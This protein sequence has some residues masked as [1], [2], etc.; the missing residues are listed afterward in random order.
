MDKENQNAN[1]GIDIV[2][3][4]SENQNT[5]TTNAKAD[6]SHTA[7]AQDK[8]TVGNA[9]KGLCLSICE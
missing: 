7:V 6:Q 9:C 1:V 8:K 5:V 2:D 3:V 4:L